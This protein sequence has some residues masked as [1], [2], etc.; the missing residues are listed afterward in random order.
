MIRE[1]RASDIGDVFRIRTN[2]RDNL[3]SVEQLTAIGITP[4]SIL[5]DVA[6]GDL[7]FWVAADDAIIA[8]FS[9]ADRRN[10]EVFA[11][12]VDTACEGRGHGTALLAA[13]ESW[14]KSE[15]HEEA[16][17]GTGPGT[18][19]HAFYLRRGWRLTGEKSGH[20]AEDDVFRK[21]L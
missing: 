8:G 12:F 14:L 17:L 2:V 7:G 19:A 15:G 4:S 1:G 5:A 9:M 20:F 11:L 3:L 13:C 16:R 21:R 10:A 6:A 18:R